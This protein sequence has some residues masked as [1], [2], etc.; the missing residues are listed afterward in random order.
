M[1][2]ASVAG[3]GT[4]A[5]CGS[6]SP[7]LGNICGGIMGGLV[8]A[9]TAKSW[10]QKIPTKIISSLGVVTKR[11][12][13]ISTLDGQ[14]PYLNKLLLAAMKPSTAKK[15]TFTEIE[16]KTEQDMGDAHIR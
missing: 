16:I 11:N 12:D 3:A 15:E 1:L 14:S 10:V 13:T 8:G 4:G 9:T 7:G 6:V 5:T 2:V